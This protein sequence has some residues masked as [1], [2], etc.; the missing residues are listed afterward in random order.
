MFSI[1]YIKNEKTLLTTSGDDGRAPSS[2]L[3]IPPI[4]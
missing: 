3:H 1:E 4:R 2:L